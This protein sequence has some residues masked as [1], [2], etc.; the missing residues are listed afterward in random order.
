MKSNSASKQEIAKI[1]QFTSVSALLS[2]L[3]E[4]HFSIKA[5][6]PDDLAK[7]LASAIEKNELTIERLSD[8]IAEIE[9]NGG[10]KIYLRQALQ[11]EDLEKTKAKLLG[12]W[13]KRKIELSKQN[14]VRSSNAGKRPTFVYIFWDSNYIKI[15]YS[16]MHDDVEFDY[17]TEEAVHTPRLVNIVFIIDVKDGFTQIRFDPAGDKHIHKDEDGKISE[18]AYETYYLELLQSLFPDLIFQEMNLSKVANHIAFK[19]GAKFILNREVTTIS[20]NLKQTFAGSA[21]D[22]VRKSPEHIA[23]Q[24]A[25]QDW[26]TEDLTGYWLSNASNQELTR[27][28]FMRISR[29][30]SMIR[31][32]RDCLEK[33]LNYGLN[34]IRKIQA[35]V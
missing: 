35:T 18:K 27:N 30:T 7:K 28:L 3:R 32:Q 25:G 4:N 29:R 21:R 1:I 31:V 13:K 20:N 22:D 23:A 5:S 9:E 15:K 10:K 2:W 33:E 17:D 24:A 8:A 26:L 34:Q 14:F 6:G 11:F 12:E 19:E 16:E